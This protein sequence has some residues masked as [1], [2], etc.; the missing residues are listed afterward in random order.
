M[1]IL[2]LLIG[3]IFT[4]TI[5]GLFG[6]GGGILFTPILF[7][8]FASLE[9]AE[10]AVW[11]IGTSLL[12]TFLA[13]ISSSIQQR[14]EKNSYLKEGI[15]VGLIGSI[16]IYF[17]KQ[18]VMSEWFTEEVFVFMFA[19]LLILVAFLFLRKS[20]R[21]HQ[22]IENDRDLKFFEASGTGFTGGFMASLAGIGGGVVMVPALNLVFKLNLSKSVSISS[23][24]IVFISLSG[25]LQYAL[26]GGF[27][28]GA[29]QYTLGYVDFGTAL[30][31][32]F[33]A[34]IGGFLGVKAGKSISNKI[35]NIL[36]AILL[37]SISSYML[38]SLI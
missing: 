4:G 10:P 29:T 19:L 13:S 28:T 22:K 11:A 21:T 5:A 25:W 34:F 20:K 6:V 9:V 16:G 24:A 14:T 33:G 12:C 3:G 32:L 37:F 2:L 15:L 18:I 26:F 27:P 1:I 17:G 38:L 7:Y 36:F 30:P 8:L 23:L 35:T 31:L